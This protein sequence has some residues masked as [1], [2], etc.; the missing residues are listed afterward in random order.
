M[1]STLLTPWF[2]EL[3]CL[4]EECYVLAFGVPAVLMVIAI[5][6]TRQM[7]N[8]FCKFNFFIFIIS[9]FFVCGKTGYKIVLP[10]RNVVALF[11]QCIGVSQAW[12]YAH[13]SLQFTSTYYHIPQTMMQ[14]SDKA[15]VRF[16]AVL[17]SEVRAVLKVSVLFIT[18]PMFWAL[19][20]QQV[21]N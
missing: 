20:D 8:S 10:E 12:T 4:G 3:Y 21:S 17:V 11:F 6:K 1:I 19:Y 16:G 5:G 18:F 15:K 14:S 13:C 7:E 9:V 2:R